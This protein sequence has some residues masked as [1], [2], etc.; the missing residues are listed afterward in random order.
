MSEAPAKA[1][2]LQGN[3]GSGAS[4]SQL[5]E[6]PG[7]GSTPCQQV[8]QSGRAAPSSDDWQCWREGMEA[9][10]DIEPESEVDRVWREAIERRAA[11]RCFA[12]G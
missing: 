12:S 9:L 1:A 2:T 4:R 7:R 3:E 11:R 6:T 5:L 10:A 8:F